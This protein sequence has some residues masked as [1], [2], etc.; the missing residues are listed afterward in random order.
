[1]TTSNI[2]MLDTKD[3][4]KILKIGRSSAYNLMKSDCF[5]S[6]KIGRKYLISEETLKEWLKDNEFSEII[7]DE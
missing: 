1:M 4:Q 2:N 5:P 3:L 7:L 6:I